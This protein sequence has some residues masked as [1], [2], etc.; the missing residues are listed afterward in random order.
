M[1]FRDFADA[2]EQLAPLLLDWLTAESVLIAIAPGG[3]PVAQAA[4]ATGLL[5]DL[6]LNIYGPAIAPGESVTELA[7]QLPPELAPHPRLQLPADLAGRT[8]VVIDD[9]VETGTAARAMGA[10][11]RDA[12]AATTV[13]AVPVCP[14]EVE[15]EL[16]TLFDEVI[17]IDRP[18][19]RRPLHWHYETFE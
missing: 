2:G 1:K 14:R 10:R 16:R 19:V 5:P 15:P 3:V 8:V 13:F 12:G 11:L 7:T 4:Q 9:G 18:F 6:P 17:A